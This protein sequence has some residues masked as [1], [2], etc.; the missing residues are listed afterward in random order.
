M[1]KTVVQRLRLGPMDNFQYLIALPEAGVCA[2][3]DA[4]WEPERV[5]A[6]ARKQGCELKAILLTHTHYDHAQQATRL[7]ERSGA[8]IYVHGAEAAKVQSAGVEVVSTAEGTRIPLGHAEIE[9]LHTPGHS[10]G[11]QCFLLGNKLFSGD[12]LFVNAVGR[13]DL[14]GGDEPS[15]QASLRRLAGL[16]P[17]TTVLPGHDY[18][19]TPQ[20]TVGAQR[21]RN[22]FMRAALKGPQ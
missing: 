1:P 8:T 20:C 22:P 15:M 11:S 7:A 5:E 2:V 18:G 21:T 9:C 6:A 12:T 16:D 17:A 10:R 3:V 4:G 19:P 14:P 13:V